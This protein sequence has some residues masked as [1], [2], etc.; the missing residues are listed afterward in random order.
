MVIFSQSRSRGGKEFRDR[1]DRV[2]TLVNLEV[3]KG[4]RIEIELIEWYCGNL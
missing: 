1:A 2:V 3:V 4:K